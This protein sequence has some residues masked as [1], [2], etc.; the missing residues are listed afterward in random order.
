MQ[1]KISYILQATYLHK[2]TGNTITFAQFEDRGL[3]E[4]KRNLVEEKSI[5]VSI[6]E[7]STD[8]RSQGNLEWKLRASKFFMQDMLDLKYVTVLGKR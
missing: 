8:K 3:L 7:S 6:D 2:Q 5:Q 1:H 4:I